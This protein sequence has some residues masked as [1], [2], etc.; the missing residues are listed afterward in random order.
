MSTLL[1]NSRLS[2][3]NMTTADL[4][5]VLEVERLAYDYPWS[6][7]ILHDCVRVGYLCLVW[8][9]D[10]NLIGHGVMSIGAGECQILNLCVHPHWQG[11]GLGQR[12][13]MRL[14]NMGRERQ[15]DTAFLE[16]RADNNIALQLYQ[17]AGF[18]EIGIRR[19]YY[20]HSKGRMDAIVCAK[21]L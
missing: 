19:G 2:L 6:R 18:N 16:V 13:L 21:I 15:A 20:P 3:R 5:A 9:L 10:S 4:D 7:E 14:L 1:K 8:Q 17:K 12:M 11:Q